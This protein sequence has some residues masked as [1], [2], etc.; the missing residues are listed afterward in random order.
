MK[1]SH[2]STLRRR[3]Q[4]SIGGLVAAGGVAALAFA[5]V[6]AMASPS[7]PSVKGPLAINGSVRG[8]AALAN[9]P[10]IPLDY[11]GVV[12]T[13][14]VIDLGNGNATT[15]TLKTGAGNFVVTQSG[16]AQQSQTENPK[17]CHIAF[18]EDLVVK[19]DPTK[20]TGRFAGA[21]GT[22]AAQITFAGTNPRYT[23]GP[24]KGQCNFSE[25]AEPT[26]KSAVA[27]FVAAAVVTTH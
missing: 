17:T 12:T 2:P 14:G 6:P 22:G 20:S 11:R 24:H 19:L 7:A 21:T 15:H 10:K 1:D 26:A 23:S 16:K 18:V 3:V 8:K 9:A 4:R 5:A 27:T 25:N 13:S